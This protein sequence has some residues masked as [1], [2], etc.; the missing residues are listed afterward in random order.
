[1]AEE[2]RRDLKMV[3]ETT[4]AGG[5]FRNVKIMGESVLSGDVDCIKL[6]CTGEITVNGGLRALEL[7]LTG[8]CDVKGIVHAVK[9]GG[10]GELDVLSGIRAEDIKFT[11]NVKTKG[12]CEAASFE[13]FGA[14][15]I[16]GLLSAEKLEVSMYGPCV[17]R[18]IGGGTLRFKRSKATVFKRLINS[19]DVAALSA[20][21]IEGDVVDLEHTSASLVR[22]NNV[23]IGSGCEI[24]RVEYRDTL[25][26]HKSAIVKEKI[27]I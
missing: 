22:G 14:F 13:V 5:K 23:K 27:K 7:K 18:E 15:Q 3:G 10:R 19:E 8:E 1:M 21:S 9:I 6:S 16:D 4:S 20:Q 25:D 26:I 2:F 11:G 12:D 17:A 24:D